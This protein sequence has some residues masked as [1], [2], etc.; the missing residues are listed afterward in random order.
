M[1]ETGNYSNLSTITSPNEA[2]RVPCA[3][4]QVNYAALQVKHVRQIHWG[5]P[6]V[7]PAQAQERPDKDNGSTTPRPLWRAS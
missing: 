7:W 5:K 6:S 3:D 2:A 4:G 1:L